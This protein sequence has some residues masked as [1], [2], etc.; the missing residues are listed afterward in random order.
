MCR[1]FMLPLLLILGLCAAVPLFAGPTVEPPDD[2]R[3][4]GMNRTKF[5]HSRMLVEYEDGTVG[6]T[7]S[8]NCTA[9]DLRVNGAKKLKS[10]KVGDYVTK[11]AIDARTATWTIGGD[12]R[13]VMTPVAKWA[14]ANKKEA[15]R[16]IAKHGGKLATY[17]EA[18][19]ATRDELAAEEEGDGDDGGVV[20]DCCKNKN[21]PEK[22]E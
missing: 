7:C 13:G 8:I 16:Y 12:K 18:L 22:Q 6:G 9:I 2:C 3:Y 1:R 20:C 4:C 14:F 10:L 19:A 21:K 15:E 11:Q 17:E 5:A